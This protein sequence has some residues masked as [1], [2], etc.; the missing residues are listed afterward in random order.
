MAKEF[1]KAESTV[2]EITL[3]EH[4]EIVI[5]M[6]DLPVD[7]EIP[8]PTSAKPSASSST[9]LTL[10]EEDH[11]WNLANVYSMNWDL[12]SSAL[13]ALGFAS[14]SSWDY[15]EAYR[16]LKRQKFVPSTKEEYIFCKPLRNGRST[17]T[18]NKSKALRLLGTFEQ[19]KKCAKK[20]DSQKVAC[21]QKLK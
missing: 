16:E 19:I 7:E 12:I 15:Y 2:K 17:Q 5:S 3:N 10:D 6:N 20:R 1:E 4:G 8:K 11:L 18:D 9:P 14:R 13:S 21:D